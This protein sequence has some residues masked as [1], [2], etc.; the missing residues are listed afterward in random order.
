[1]F[2]LNRYDETHK[3]LKLLAVS[4]HNVVAWNILQETVDILPDMTA[5]SY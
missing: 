4:K 5:C 1:M 3:D 2:S